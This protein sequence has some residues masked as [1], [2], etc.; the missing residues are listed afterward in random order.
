MTDEIAGVIE[1]Q[2]M[3]Q[4][5]AELERE[6][7]AL[8]R[9]IVQIEKVLE[10]H[11]R[12]LEADEAALAA[13][14]KER[15]KLEGEIQVQEQ[16]QSRLRDQMMEAKTNDQYRAF[17]HEI[18]YCGQAIRKCEDRILELMEESEPL[19]LN[20]RTARGELERERQQ[21]ARE[22]QLARRRSEVDQKQLAELQQARSGRAAGL[23][24]GIVG[25][26]ER[27]R[28]KKPGVAVADGTDGRCAAC[29]ISQRPQFF[30][31][32]KKCEQVMFCESCG[33]ILYYNP[34]VVEIETPAPGGQPVA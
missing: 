6:I 21:V 1:I 26:Y 17:Q 7:A 12:K 11:Q 5:I 33:A 31:D 28:K 10:S 20:V 4:R 25:A 15:K 3:D 13:N 18:D 23:A 29:H 27:I 24:P 34:V 2:A 30:Q 32:L 16:K 8:P 14:Q 19:E 9:H 22:S